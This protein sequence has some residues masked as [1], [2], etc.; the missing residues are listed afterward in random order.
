MSKSKKP[1]KDSVSVK[2]SKELREKFDK[3]I[4]DADIE[5]IIKEIEK[6]RDRPHKTIGYGVIAGLISALI[7]W[8]LVES[9]SSDAKVEKETHVHIEE[10]TYR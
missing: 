8:A 3:S 1:G 9:R 6:S 4:E 7:W 2:P 5:L 10:A